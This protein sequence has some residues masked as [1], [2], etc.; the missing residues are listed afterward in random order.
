VILG[1][2]MYRSELVPRRMT[3]LGL[4]GG[5]AVMITGLLVVFNVIER[6]GALQGLAGLI[7][8][9][10]EL[11]LSIYCIVKG[12]R[13]SSPIFQPMSESVTRLPASDSALRDKA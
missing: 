1:Y 7:E 2:L 13:A 11:S 8:G 9:L 12:F 10:W 4:I 5:P 6:S 3:W